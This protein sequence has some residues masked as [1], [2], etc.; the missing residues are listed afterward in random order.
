[1]DN[2]FFRFWR[3]VGNVLLINILW[4]ICC[5]PVITVGASCAAMY[6]AIFDL[7]EGK[8]NCVKNFFRG[9]RNCFKLATKV[10]LTLIVCLCAVYLVPQMVGALQI[11]LLSMAAAG[12]VFAALIIMWLLLVCVFPLVAYFD[13]SLKKTLRNAAFIAIKYRKKSVTAAVIAAIP[14]ILMFIPELFLWT[15]GFWALIFPGAMAYFIASRFA[16]I[17][18]SYNNKRKEQE[19]E[20]QE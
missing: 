13:T 17:L 5:I 20:V 18:D 3:K 7:R 9:F 15:S 16:P 1:M 14:V 12:V 6:R 19:K 2:K 4:L 8:E 10:W 11:Q